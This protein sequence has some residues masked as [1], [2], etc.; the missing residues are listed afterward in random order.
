MSLP[1]I[2]ISTWDQLKHKFL[3]KFYP[4]AKIV[5]LR[6]ELAAPKQGVGETF[7][8]YYKRFKELEVNCYNHELP[9][10][11]LIEKFLNGL[12]P[13]ELRLQNQCA[14]GN[15]CKLYPENV[16]RLIEETV[17]RVCYQV[18]LENSHSRPVNQVD[19]SDEINN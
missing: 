13:I 6:R 12:L 10:N 7:Y 11:V 5:I 1:T 9:Q 19:V 14:N 3:D 18:T 4:A 8:E 15:V 16:W 2:S 17:D